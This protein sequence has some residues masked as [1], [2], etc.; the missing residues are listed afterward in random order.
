HPQHQAMGGQRMVVE[1]LDPQVIAPGNLLDCQQNRLFQSNRRIRCHHGA[2]D[3][4][5]A[6]IG[7]QLLFAPA[8]LAGQQIDDLVHLVEGLDAAFV[9]GT[10][11]GHS[12]FLIDRATPGV[13]K[14]PALMEERMDRDKVRPHS[15]TRRIDTTAGCGDR[16]QIS[17]WPPSSMT[18]LVGMRKNSVASSM[19][20]EST[21]N[22]RLRQTQR[23]ARLPATSF[24]RPTKNEVSSRLK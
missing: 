10:V 11:E 21:M 2:E 5:P 4:A 3:A 7:P 13:A 22:R 17:I 23:R 14:A 15:A 24:S 19:V 16:A 12:S 18:R 1:H 6:V 9:A 20:L 8:I